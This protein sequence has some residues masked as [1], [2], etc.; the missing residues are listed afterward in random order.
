MYKKV[1]PFWWEKKIFL[2]KLLS[3][4]GNCCGKGVCVPVCVCMYNLLFWDHQRIWS[5]LLLFPS[6]GLGLVEVYHI[7]VVCKTHTDC[8]CHWRQKLWTQIHREVLSSSELRWESQSPQ[9]FALVSITIHHIAQCTWICSG[10][11]KWRVLALKSIRSGC[12]SWPCY[13]LAG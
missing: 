7:L 4:W 12:E 2:Y 13:F 10:G 5:V 11:L 3:P 8:R 1:F 6:C 9:Y